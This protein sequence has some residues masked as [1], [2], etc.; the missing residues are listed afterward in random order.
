MILYVV[1]LHSDTGTT[2]G[3]WLIARPRQLLDII[4]ALNAQYQLALSEVA[5]YADRAVD[6][7]IR[8]IHVG[9]NDN[10]MFYVTIEPV[11]PELSIVDL[12]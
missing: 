8:N 5:Q 7:S 2:F 10:E 3:R 9:L 4:E 12:L 11:A 6:V 1:T